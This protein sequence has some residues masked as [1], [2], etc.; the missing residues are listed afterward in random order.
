VQFDDLLVK[1]LIVA[2]IVSFLLAVFDGESGAAF[3]EPFVI[4]L[5]LIANAT[6]RSQSRSAADD[7]SMQHASARSRGPHTWRDDENM[8]RRVWSPRF[9]VEQLP[10]QGAC[11]QV[12]FSQLHPHV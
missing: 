3:V 4:I 1:I 12:V 8:G 5:I 11:S 10:P 2:A 6:V 9:R 7:T